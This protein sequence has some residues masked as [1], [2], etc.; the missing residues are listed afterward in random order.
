MLLHIGHSILSFPFC[1]SSSIFLF[2]VE[3]RE[4]KDNLVM[5]SFGVLEGPRPSSY[6]VSGL[7]MAKMILEE[8]FLEGDEE[9]ELS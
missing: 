5:G 3:E 1:F 9:V 2:V 4:R 6:L 8:G 7:V